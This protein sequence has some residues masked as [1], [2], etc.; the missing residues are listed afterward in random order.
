MADERP[1][2][3]IVHGVGEVPRQDH[4]EAEP[5][6]LPDSEGAVEDANVGV[7]AHQGEVSDAFLLKEVVD[8]LPVFADAVEAKDIDGGMLALPGIRSRPFLDV[9]IVAAAVSIVYREVAR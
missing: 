5:G 9:R 2:A 3:R 4:L 7:N 8:L 1:L 6:H